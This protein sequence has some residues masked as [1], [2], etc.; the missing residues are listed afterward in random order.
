MFGDH[1][2]GCRGG[3]VQYFCFC[4]MVLD[5][6]CVP[7]TW[8]G[9]WVQRAFQAVSPRRGLACVLRVTRIRDSREMC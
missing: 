3:G 6:L 4:G 2:F 1:N 5:C 8:K 7:G 9:L